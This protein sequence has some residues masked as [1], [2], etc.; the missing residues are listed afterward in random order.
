MPVEQ[1]S[2]AGHPSVVLDILHLTLGLLFLTDS[3][4]IEQLLSKTMGSH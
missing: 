4:V 3:T 2:S 1:F